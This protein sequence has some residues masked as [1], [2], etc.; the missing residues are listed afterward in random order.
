MSADAGIF[1]SPARMSA[2]ETGNFTGS[3]AAPSAAAAAPASKA[4]LRQPGNGWP[5]A[6]GSVPM[7]EPR[8]AACSTS[9]VV[10]TAAAAAAA[11]DAAAA[12]SEVLLAVACADAALALPAEC[13]PAPRPRELNLRPLP[14]LPRP[15]VA[16]VVAGRALTPELPD[17]AAAAAGVSCNFT[18]GAKVTGRLEALEPTPSLT[19]TTEA[20][21]AT[22]AAAV[23][24]SSEKNG[25]SPP[26]PVGVGAMEAAFARVFGLVFP[27]LLDPLARDPPAASAEAS[28]APEFKEVLL[29]NIPAAV[30]AAA[31]S[32]AAVAAAASPMGGPSAFALLLLLPE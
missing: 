7:S 13:R 31:D 25:D 32:A 10:S 28:E 17:A 23:E 8:H 14:P 20:A 30:A 1:T 4:F 27:E 21:V 9:L 3:D 16:V 18:S 19:T 26:A 5:A 24:P 22:A 11:V 15:R 6:S 12:A 2:T 29:P